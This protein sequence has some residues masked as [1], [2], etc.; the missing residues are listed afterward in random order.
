MEHDDMELKQS[1]LGI[2]ALLGLGPSNAVL[3]AIAPTWPA[4]LGDVNV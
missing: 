2:G 1:L 3:I 4:H